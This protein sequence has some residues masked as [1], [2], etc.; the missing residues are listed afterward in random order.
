MS[1]VRELIVLRAHGLH[2]LDGLGPMCGEMPN[3]LPRNMY[4]C[5]LS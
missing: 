3:L 1:N 5:H 2:V 4:S